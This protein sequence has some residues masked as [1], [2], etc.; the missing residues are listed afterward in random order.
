MQDAGHSG[1]AMR[2]TGWHFVPT[3]GLKALFMITLTLFAFSFVSTILSAVTPSGRG[4]VASRSL[5]APANG[6][7]CSGSKVGA[8]PRLAFWL[9]S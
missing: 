7:R 3:N 9:G 5:M 1:R 4:G 8:E 6:G 2:R